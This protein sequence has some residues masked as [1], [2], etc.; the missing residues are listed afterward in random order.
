MASDA[1]RIGFPP[2]HPGEYL[3]EDILPALGMNITQLADHLGV[4]RATLSDLIHGKRG[5]SMQMAIR[6]G[7]AFETGARFWIAL[8]MQHDLWLEEQKFSGKVD[9]VPRRNNEPETAGRLG[10]P[11]HIPP[12]AVP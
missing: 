11:P 8:Q 6:L 5:V 9:P 3:K 12:R 4:T 10:Q 2:P 7:K 1:E